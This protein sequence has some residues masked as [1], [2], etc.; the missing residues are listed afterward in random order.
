MC[1]IVD[2]PLNSF[3]FAF[4]VFSAHQQS[5]SP[6][7]LK[8]EIKWNCQNLGLNQDG[9]F[10]FRQTKQES[11]RKVSPNEGLLRTSPSS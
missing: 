7:G 3:E 4:S 1:R 6:S 2:L 9:S 10:V 8:V 11:D 5:T